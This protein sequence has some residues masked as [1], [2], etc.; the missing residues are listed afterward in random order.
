MLRL[1]QDPPDYTKNYR[2]T[3]WP[4][5]R[6]RIQR[7]IEF[8]RLAA[9]VSAADLSA[10]DGA[11]LRGLGLPDSALT[12]GDL[13]PPPGPAGDGWLKGPIEK[14]IE[15]L[16]PVDLYVSTE[17]LE[18]L[19]KPFGHLEDVRGRASRLLLS[20]P[21]HRPDEEVDD[22]PEHLW[23][24]DTVD[25]VVGLAGIGWRLVRYETLDYRDLNGYRTM[26]GLFE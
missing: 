12:F 14:T 15:L 19:R 16:G 22:N 3:K 24:W 18:H 2:H 25:L 6:D 7:T 17:T 9:P 10:G 20:T 4:D 21:I 26:L 23:Q 1:R 5:H 13:V 8:A 11:V